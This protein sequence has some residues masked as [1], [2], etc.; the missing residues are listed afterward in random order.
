MPFTSAFVSNYHSEEAHRI[1]YR[2]MSLYEIPSFLGEASNTKSITT[3]QRFCCVLQR[4]H[5]GLRGTEQI[6]R[7]GGRRVM[8]AKEYNG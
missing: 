7:A 2:S 5:P 6:V 8:L 4:K 3:K 1:A